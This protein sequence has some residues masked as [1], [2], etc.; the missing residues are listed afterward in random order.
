MKKVKTIREV[1]QRKAWYLE[2]LVKNTD[3]AAS[4]IEIGVMQLAAN[5]MPSRGK[6]QRE[7]REQH[8]R[9]TDQMMDRLAT[10]L[11]HEVIR[12]FLFVEEHKKFLSPTSRK[13]L[14][15]R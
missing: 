14:K 9:D 7:I 1:I 4:L 11:G 13:I 12:T 5:V 6:I 15:L 8:C 10:K 2:T 3:I